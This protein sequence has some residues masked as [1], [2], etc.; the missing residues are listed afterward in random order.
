MKPYFA[1]L[2]NQA[3]NKA[4]EASLSI[5]GISHPPLRN[6]LSKQLSDDEPLVTEPVFEPMFAWET[7][8]KTMTDL[9]KENL[10][11]QAVVNALNAES[12]F[13]SN[14][15]TKLGKIFYRI[16][17]NLA[18]LQAVQVQVKPNVLWYRCWKIYIEKC[19]KITNR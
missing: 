12:G 11:S 14:I 7:D 17:L 9:V 19:P 1:A 13:L 6:H 4:K 10:L 18:L 2:R 8:S 3:N 15:N 5:L 16:N